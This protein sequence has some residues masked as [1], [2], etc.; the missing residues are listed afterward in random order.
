MKK[1]LVLMF[2]LI[3]GGLKAD[4]NWMSNSG[5]Q[6]S[7]GFAGAFVAGNVMEYIHYEYGKSDDQYKIYFAHKND[8]AIPKIDEPQWSQIL[9]RA[10]IHIGWGAFTGIMFELSRCR[11]VEGAQFSWDAIRWSMLGGLTSV[12]VR[13]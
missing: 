2:L 12:I 5:A 13:F 8:M 7:L 1:I 10:Q 11:S 4:E 6:F 3:A 9:T